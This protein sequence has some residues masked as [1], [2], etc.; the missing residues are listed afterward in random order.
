M[1]NNELATL[2]LLCARAVIEVVTDCTGGP[3]NMA[4]LRRVANIRQALIDFQRL[5]GVDDVASLK[6]ALG[7]KEEDGD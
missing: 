3:D 1:S 4:D 5:V 7:Y 6:A 2:V